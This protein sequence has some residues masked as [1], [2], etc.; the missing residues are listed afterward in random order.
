MKA[1]HL[2]QHIHAGYWL[3]GAWTSHR[4]TFRTAEGF[5]RWCKARQAQGC[6]VQWRFC[7]EADQRPAW[8]A[9]PALC[10]QTAAA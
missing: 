1:N 4:Y 2:D 8:R 3:H 10:R 5:E 6:I 7:N 9:A